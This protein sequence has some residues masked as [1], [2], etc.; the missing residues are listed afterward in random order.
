[1]SH[2]EDYEVLCSVGSGSFGTCQKIKRK[3][4]GKILVWKVVRYREMKKDQLKRLL[5]EVKILMD[6]SH[7][8]IVQYFHHFVDW[9]QKKLYIVMEHCE[10]GDLDTL[11]EHC[12]IRGMFL[13]EN[14]ILRI[15]L[16]LASA[17]MHCHRRPDR[18][19]VLHQDLKPANVFLDK[20]LNVKLGDFG[21]AEVLPSK[22]HV[23]TC[24]AGTPLY[25]SPEKINESQ[26]DERSDIWSLGCLM[27]ELCAFV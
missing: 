8:N 6:L 5:S 24:R 12:Q 27:Y 21:L 9:E 1:M 13:S 19:V 20:T 25:M 17:L 15:L 10:G 2:F 7:R 11:I 16:Q 26:Y 23:C 3:S 4:D 18:T 14:F 22:E